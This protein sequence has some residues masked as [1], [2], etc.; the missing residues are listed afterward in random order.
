MNVTK[1][2]V[3]ANLNVHDLFK[4]EMGRGTHT[5]FWHE[6]WSG[7]SILKD[8]FPLLFRLESKKQCCVSDR[9]QRVGATIQWTWGWKRAPST[10]EENIEKTCCELIL[11]NAQITN[12]EDKW[13]WTHDQ[14]RLFFVSSMR[15]L[16]KTSFCKVLP[17]KHWWNNWVPIKINF[18][19]W[20][21][22]LNRLP[23]K[24]E[25]ARR[26]VPMP[27][28]FCSFYSQ[29]EENDLHMF[30]EC[31]WV[32]DVW[33]VWIT[34]SE[35]DLRGVQN[36][37]Q[38]LHLSHVSCQSPKQK[39]VMHA[40]MMVTL[41]VIWKARNDRIFNNR[42]STPGSLLDKIKAQLFLWIK[43]RG[44]ELHLNWISW[45]TFPFTVH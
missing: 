40:V 8:I 16:C 41:W 3:G 11:Q 10:Q 19:G 30:L 42:W 37:E 14:S 17:Y 29:R 7:S 45:C 2:L 31:S 35:L 28:S 24:S 9:Y 13:K 34:W 5:S 26:G 12:E 33:S 25:L 22:V 44:K 15:N 21:A 18:F 36:V 4:K 23:T 39:K 6:Y 20:R 43:N 1:E 38:L 27:S 32:K